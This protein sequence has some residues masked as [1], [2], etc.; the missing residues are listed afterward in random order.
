LGNELNQKAA[1]F[2]CQQEKHIP[3]LSK[4]PDWLW[5]LSDIFLELLFQAYNCRRVTLSSI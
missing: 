1:W 5:G 4:L 2:N 3:F